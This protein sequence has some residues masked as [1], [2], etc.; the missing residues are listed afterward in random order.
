MSHNNN[1]LFYTH[2]G[3]I[4]SFMRS[5]TS[6]GGHTDQADGRTEKATLVLF[7][8]HIIPVLCSSSCV[9]S[10]QLLQQKLAR[11]TLCE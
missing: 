6:F 5:S 9:L 3:M 11:L 10:A 2:S 4:K 7:T 1:T 8:V